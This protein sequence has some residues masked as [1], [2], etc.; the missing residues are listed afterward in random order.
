MKAEFNYDER[1]ALQVG[2]NALLRYN[3]AMYISIEEQNID[4]PTISEYFKAEPNSMKEREFAKILVIAAKDT[5][6]THPDIPERNRIKCALRGAKEFHQVLEASKNDYL[7]EIGYFGA[8]LSAEEKYNQRQKEN[9]MVRNATIAKMA[10]SR[11]KK[12]PTDILKKEG[13]KQ[14]ARF[15]GVDLSGGTATMI[16]IAT[17]VVCEMIPNEAKQKAKDSACYMM[18]RAGNQIEKAARKLA[19]TPIGRTV[20][21]CYTQYVQ[22]VVEKGYS[23]MEE[24]HDK[25]K[26]GLQSLWTRVKSNWA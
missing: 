25:A 3:K 18:E 12:V 4:I 9:I 10:E 13:I 6:L 26:T 16:V 11:L 23:K 7:K 1:F 20:T 19:D 21:N 8:G 5:Y 17:D 14:A 15:V 24:L 22:P 2:M